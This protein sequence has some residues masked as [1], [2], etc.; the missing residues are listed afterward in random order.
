MAKKILFSGTLSVE[1]APPINRDCQPCVVCKHPIPFNGI[2]VSGQ[3]VNPEAREREVA[4]WRLGSGSYLEG[5]PE[6]AERRVS[7]TNPV[8]FFVD[9]VLCLAVFLRDNLGVKTLL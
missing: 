5:D 9:D 8:D 4:Q 2:R 7:K 6:L 3:I 1:E